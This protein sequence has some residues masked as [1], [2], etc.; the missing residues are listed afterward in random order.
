MDLEIGGYTLIQKILLILMS[1][2][3]EKIEV[4]L[5]QVKVSDFC[6]WLSLKDKKEIDFKIKLYEFGEGR[7]TQY[8][9]VDKK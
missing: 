3:K 4:K 6:P 1:K 9:G 8:I 2:K 7:N 5:S